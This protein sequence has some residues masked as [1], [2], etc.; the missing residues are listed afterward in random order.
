MLKN[1]KKYTKW[2][3]II[4]KKDIISLPHEML[5]RYSFSPLMKRMEFHKG[6]VVQRC[7]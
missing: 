5:I 1:A 7:D 6:K 3:L 2:A 4:Y